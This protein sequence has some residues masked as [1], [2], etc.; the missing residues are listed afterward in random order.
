MTDI[1]DIDIRDDILRLLAGIGTIRLPKLGWRPILSG[2]DR[3]PEV[4]PA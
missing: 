4:T 3:P 1:R 2:S